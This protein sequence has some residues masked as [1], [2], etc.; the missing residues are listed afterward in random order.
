MKEEEI[1]KL[2]E[3]KYPQ[4]TLEGKV[5]IVTGAGKGM[6]KWDALGLAWAGAD[7]VA[8]ARTF[9]DVLKTANEIEAMGRKALALQGDVSDIE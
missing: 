4:W 8:I 6:G 9:E 5:A 7:V 2:E 1:A 3:I